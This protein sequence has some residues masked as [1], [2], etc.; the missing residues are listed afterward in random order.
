MCNLANCSGH[1]EFKTLW[2]PTIVRLRLAA[3]NQEI[4][5]Y[6]MPEA[7][8][9]FFATDLREKNQ[10][11]FA[12]R[13]IHLSHEPTPQASSEERIQAPNTDDAALSASTVEYEVHP[14]VLQIEQC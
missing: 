12:F 7:L 8:A 1:F 11:N 14:H 5:P 3:V 10:E 9:F 2:S 13:E 4:Y 6:A